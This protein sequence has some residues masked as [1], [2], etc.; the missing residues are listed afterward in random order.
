M[1]V[2]LGRLE[3]P[4]APHGP[5]GTP[6]P[7]GRATCPCGPLVALLDLPRS[8]QGPPWSRKN[9]QNWHRVWTFLGIDFLRNQK[10]AENRNW[11]WAL[12]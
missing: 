12:N 8:F 5:G 9:H 3:S 4:G 7:P 11:H 10:Q 1:A 6:Y 2:E